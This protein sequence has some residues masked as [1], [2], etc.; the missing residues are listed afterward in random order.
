MRRMLV[1]LGL[2]IVTGTASFAQ[3]PAPA[4]AKPAAPAAQAPAPAPAAAA[5]ALPFPE[6]AKI[7]FVVLQGVV[8]ESAEGKLAS[9]RVQALQQ[10]KVGELNER[11]KTAQSLQEKLDKSGA[12]MS[13]AA[14]ADLTK[15]VERANV[16]MQRATQDAQAEVQELQQQ[17]QEEFQRRIAPIIEAVGKE[18]GLHYIFNGPDSGLVWA[19]ASLDITN[20]VVKKFDLA[21][22]AAP[23]PAKPQG[24]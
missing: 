2:V 5:P 12:V 17:L 15:Q 22:P 11:Q 20:D 16:D 8:A 7:A 13:E 14:R 23:A 18:K 10:K 6:G 24:Q 9:A 3:A 19:D 21:K 1:A 4:T